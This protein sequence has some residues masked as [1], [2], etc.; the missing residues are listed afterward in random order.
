M[1][2][3]IRLYSMLL[4]I[5]PN[6]E[7]TYIISV[8][9]TD[10]LG[11]GISVDALTTGTW[12]LYK[13]TSTVVNER[14][15]IAIPTDGNIVLTGDDLALIT[16][17]TRKRTIKVHVVYDSTYGEDLTDNAEISFKIKNL[18]TI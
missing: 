11:A 10:A 7:G 5:Q 15:D 3:L 8:T 12:T 13:G 17:E 16:G 1:K 2:S 9:I 4:D 14:E 18:K 6:E